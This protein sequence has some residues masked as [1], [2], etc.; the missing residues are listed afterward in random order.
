MKRKDEYSAREREI[1]LLAADGLTDKEIADRLGIAISTVSTYWIRLRG[2][3]GAVN[4]SQAL[5]K[6]LGEELREA[7]RQAQRALEDRDVLIE[8]AQDYAIFSLDPGGKI[9]DWNN[10]INRVLGYAEDEFVGQHFSMVFTPE[11]ARDGEPEVEMSEATQRGRYLDKRWHLKKDG[12]QV[13]IDGCIV[14]LRDEHTGQV[15]RFS[16]IMRDDTERKGLEEEVQRLQ[17]RISRGGL[18]TQG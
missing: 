15:R 12:T 5:V 8:Q 9:L 10:G 2:K 16:K 3:S 7:V 18:P 6:I 14:A 17:G 13:W 4:R 11:D 1:L